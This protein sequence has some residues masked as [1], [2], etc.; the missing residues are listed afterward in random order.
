MGNLNRSLKY[1]SLP[2]SAFGSRKGS[3]FV[4]S[5]RS[6]TKESLK[7]ADVNFEIKL[8]KRFKTKQ[9]PNRLDVNSLYVS[10]SVAKMN[11]KLKTSINSINMN[12]TYTAQKSSN[13]QHNYNKSVVSHKDWKY[14]N[15]SITNIFG[16]HKFSIESSTDRT[17]QN[18]NNSIESNKENTSSLWRQIKQ[19]IS[20]NSNKLSKYLKVWKNSK[21]SIKI[22]LT[23]LIPNK[24][25]SSSVNSIFWQRT[26]SFNHKNQR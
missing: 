8:S 23:D 18:I 22:N 3:K 21:N 13:K 26:G 20:N 2:P 24:S 12:N 25:P 1:V 5:D 9:S 17:N 6:W 16:K 14:D 4:E 7:L 10:E 15:K 11:K 19:D